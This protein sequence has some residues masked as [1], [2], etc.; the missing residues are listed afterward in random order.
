LIKAR[1]SSKES[2]GLYL[3]LILA[4]LIVAAWVFGAIAEDVVTNDPL[5]VVD[6]RFSAW[7]HDHSIASLTRCMLLIT[8]LHSTL[9]VTVMTFAVSAFLWTKRLRMW[10][11]RLMLA[12][13]GAMLLNF[14]LKQV[15]V[16]PRP[17]FDNPLLTLTTYSF[18]SGHTV[19]ATV[20]YGTLCTLIVSRVRQ[21][22]WRALAM[23]LAAF[24]ILL[25]G[26]S[27]IYLGVHYLS[28][29]VAAIAEGLA[30]LAFCFLSVE[31]LKRR[32]KGRQK[33]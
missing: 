28:D 16:R 23:V 33:N 22:R 26:F 2:S 17:H 25:V 30:W 9:G 31:E 24:L 1:L 6:V 3:T 12:V 5:T 14:L 29:V 15:F 10:V 11:L 7:L 19:M 27:R 21:W 4:T 18:P 20:F 32:R 8:D 13:F